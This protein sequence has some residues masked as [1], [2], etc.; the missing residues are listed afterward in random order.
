MR[1]FFPW[2]TENLN[3]EA[4]LIKTNNTISMQMQGGRL[5]VVRQNIYN[6]L[7]LYNSHV[8]LPPSPSIDRKLS[9]LKILLK[10][11]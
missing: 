3:K 11:K 9:A 8:T 10:L 2:N 5:V 1:P 7:S 4:F 6:L